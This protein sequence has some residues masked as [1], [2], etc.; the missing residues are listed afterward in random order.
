MIYGPTFF[1]FLL[2]QIFDFAFFSSFLQIEFLMGRGDSALLLGVLG[3]ILSHTM[4][5]Q[6]WTNAVC[7]SFL[8]PLSSFH[9]FSHHHP[10]SL[11]QGCLKVL[12]IVQIQIK[13]LKT[14]IS[15]HFALDFL[16]FS[17]TIA[18]LFSYL[19]FNQSIE[20]PEEL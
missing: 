7:T 16:L 20:I 6:W 15:T 19:Y 5:V 17:K 18:T 1:L 11:S 2:F 8:F 4:W 12:N 10:F 3:S 14:V 9:Q 13:F